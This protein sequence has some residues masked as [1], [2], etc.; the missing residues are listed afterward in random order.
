MT[1]PIVKTVEVTCSVEHAFNVF[2][3]RIAAWWPMATHA[4]SAA[5]GKSALDV[6]I[7]PHVG[8]AIFETTHSGGCAEWGTVLVFEPSSAFA[9]TWHPGTSEE[10]QTRVDVAFVGNA[11]GGATVTLTHSGW[12]IWGDEADSKMAG[13]TVGW[14]GILAEGF[15]NVCNTSD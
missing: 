12:E 1:D 3:N 5:D 13:Y 6:S 11:A 7:E 14:A 8:G 4:V 10:K 2:V 9:M 15:K